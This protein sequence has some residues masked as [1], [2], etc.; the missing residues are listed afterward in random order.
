MI[1]PTRKVAEYAYGCT[2][3]QHY[4]YECELLYAP[5]IYFQDKAGLTWSR[6]HDHGYV[7]TGLELP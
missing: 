4:H 6:R 1:I 3:C 7:A 5:H 2:Q